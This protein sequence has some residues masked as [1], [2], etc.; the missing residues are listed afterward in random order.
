MYVSPHTA[1]DLPRRFGSELR[2]IDV[3]QESV[4]PLPMR[5]MQY[6]DRKTFFCDAVREFGT[7]RKLT[8]SCENSTGSTLS[9]V[10]STAAGVGPI[11]YCKSSQK[12]FSPFS[13]TSVFDFP[14]HHVEKACRKT[15]PV[16]CLF[17][18]RASWLWGLSLER[19]VSRLTR[20]VAFCFSLVVGNF[21]A[22]RE[23]FCKPL[24]PV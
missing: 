11:H 15:P 4:F 9:S 10:H 22:N 24:G 17:L 2:L 20:L 16:H 14:A 1:H 7:R 19:C 12:R 3:F 23:R 13:P 6:A 21:T 8:S 5:G 18:V